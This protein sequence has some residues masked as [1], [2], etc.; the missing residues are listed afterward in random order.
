MEDKL[1]IIRGNDA[2]FT[3]LV[4]DSDD[5]PIDLTDTTVYFTAKRKK[6]DTDAEAAV[7]VNVTSHTNPTEGETKISIPAAT[8]RELAIGDYFWDIQII[9]ESGVIQSCLYDI[10]TVLPNIT[11]RIGDELS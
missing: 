10:L 1:K 4:T 8:T 7:A 3:L 6:T 2:D 9:Y 5:E 11:N